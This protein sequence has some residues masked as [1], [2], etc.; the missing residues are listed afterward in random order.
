MSSREMADLTGKRHDNVLADIRGMLKA[1]KI[2]ALSF[3]G[4]YL[5]GLNRQQTEYLLDREHTDCLL[6][7]YSVPLRMKVIRRWHELEQGYAAPT[8]PQNLPEALRLAAD[9]AEQNNQLRLVVS[10][11]APKVEALARIADARGSMCLTDAAKHLGV[12]RKVLIGWL[13]E[14]RWVYRREGSTRLVAYQPREATGLLE[15]KVSV[16]GLDD[17]GEQRL[18][19]QVRVTPKGLA[20]LAQ[21]MG[22]A[23]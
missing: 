1:L 4:I 2:D 19:G 15:H 22:G 13:R 14:N 20:M 10:E 5:D 9:L 6:T 16:I 11:Q 21:K 7:G 8:I 12:Q 17:E 3:Q 18:A 23:L